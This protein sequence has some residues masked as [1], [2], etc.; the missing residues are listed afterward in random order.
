MGDGP[1]REEREAQRRLEDQQAADRRA[2]DQFITQANTPDPLA[3]RWRQ[4]QLNFLDW[5]EGKGE[6]EG[7]PLDVENAPGLGPSLALFRRARE[8]QQ[9]ERMGIGAL[10]MGL[11]ASD[12]GMAAR[13]AEQSKLRREQDAA[14]QL[15]NA[16][17]LR[18]AEAHDSIM[19]LVETEQGRRMGL[20]SLASGNSANT[21]NTYTGFVARPRRESFWKRLLLAGASGAGQAAGAFA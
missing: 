11:N 2:R 6:F 3:E 16:V 14:G 7:K 21:T 19:P 15:E 13:L 10:R 1:S 17:R 12:P 9:G 18:T 5:E 20:A 4:S 8:G